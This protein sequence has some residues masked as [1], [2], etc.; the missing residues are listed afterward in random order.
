MDWGGEGGLKA[1]TH[2]L[3]TAFRRP[4]TCIFYELKI[5]IIEVEMQG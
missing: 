4:L 2:W 5:S 3:A 1:K